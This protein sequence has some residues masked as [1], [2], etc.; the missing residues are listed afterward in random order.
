MACKYFLR[1]VGTNSTSSTYATALADGSSVSITIGVYANQP[2]SVFE[3]EDREFLGGVLE[4]S[5]TI[6]NGFEIECYPFSTYQAIDG[7]NV[8]Q[9]SDTLIKLRNLFKDK[10]FVWLALPE[11]PKLAPP[12]WR[13]ATNFSDVA[14]Q[15][16]LRVVRDGG[17]DVSLNKDTGEEEVTISLKARSI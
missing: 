4:P 6:R 5:R 14:G 17:F 13:D 7:V 15:L 10:K 12:R 1:F 3:G 8:P 9:N 2:N 16:P 11:A